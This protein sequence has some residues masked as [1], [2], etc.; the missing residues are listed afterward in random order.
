MKKLI[1][2]LEKSFNDFKL[3]AKTAQKKYTDKIT[4]FS[5]GAFMILV[6]MA[7]SQNIYVSLCLVMAVAALKEYLDM[8]KFD[9]YDFLATTI[10]GVVALVLIMYFI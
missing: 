7:I 3:F 8:Q 5:V 2:Y 10:G 4:H 1:D 6:F 9:Y